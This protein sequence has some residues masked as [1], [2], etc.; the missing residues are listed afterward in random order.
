MSWA[1]CRQAPLTLT[2]LSI[3]ARGDV[4]DLHISNSQLA[5]HGKGCLIF[6]CGGGSQDLHTHPLEKL[7]I[8]GRRSKS[9]VSLG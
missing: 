7:P 3:K 2:E 9:R 1:I 5:T 8:E 4:C 6:D